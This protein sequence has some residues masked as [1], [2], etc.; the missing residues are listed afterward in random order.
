MR[1]LKALVCILNINFL[2]SSPFLYKMRFMMPAVT[3][4]VAGMLANKERLDQ[5]RYKKA[6]ESKLDR[7][8]VREYEPQAYDLLAQV[9]NIYEQRLTE[10]QS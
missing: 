2:Y 9:N 1:L 7:Y 8:S 3:A 5:Q 6:L 4:S 10:L